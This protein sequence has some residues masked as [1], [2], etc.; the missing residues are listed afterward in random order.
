MRNHHNTVRHHATPAANGR[1]RRRGKDLRGSKGKG[2]ENGG[3]KREGEVASWLLGRMD[4]PV[5]RR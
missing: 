2:H 5:M 1:R 3:G 4:A